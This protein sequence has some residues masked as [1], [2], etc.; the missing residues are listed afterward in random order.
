MYVCMHM[1]GVGHKIRPLH[2]DLQ[3]CVALLLSINHF[4]ILHFG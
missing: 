4:L 1:Y 3:W 2:R